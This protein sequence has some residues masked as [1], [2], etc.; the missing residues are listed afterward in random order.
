MVEKNKNEAIIKNFIL[1]CRILGRT[2]ETFFLNQIL[3]ALKKEGILYVKASY[4]ETKK[5]LQCKNF[6][7]DNFFIKSGNYFTLSLKK[8]KKSKSFIKIVYE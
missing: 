8:I 7:K 3:V 5:N 6:Y 4:V 1:S 2:I